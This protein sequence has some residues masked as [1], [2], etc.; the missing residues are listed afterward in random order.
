MVATFLT[1]LKADCAYVP[2]DIRQPEA[3]LRTIA[4]DAGVPVGFWRA[5]AASQNTFAY[6]CFI[7]ELAER[8]KTDPVAYRRML[9]AEDGVGVDDARL[10]GHVQSVLS[11]SYASS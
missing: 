10:V 11:Y 3:R 2:M 9:L 7:D 6:E 5:V 1:V 4:L 8:A